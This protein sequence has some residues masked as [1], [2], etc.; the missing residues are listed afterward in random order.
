MKPCIKRLSLSGLR[1]EMTSRRLKESAPL[2]SALP[3]VF[4][5]K[6][7]FEERL[8]HRKRKFLEKAERKVI[9]RLAREQ[10]EFA[11]LN[12]VHFGNHNG[13]DSLGTGIYR[14]ND[15]ASLSKDRNQNA[16]GKSVETLNLTRFEKFTISNGHSPRFERSESKTLCSNGHGRLPGNFMTDIP[17]ENEQCLNGEQTG[18]SK[19]NSECKRTVLGPRLSL[20]TRIESKGLDWK[21]GAD[22]IRAK[23]A[24]VRRTEVTF[25]GKDGRSMSLTPVVRQFRNISLNDAFHSTSRTKSSGSQTC[26][27]K[28]VS[29]LPKAAQVQLKSSVYFLSEHKIKQQ[30]EMAKIRTKRALSARTLRH[31]SVT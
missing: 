5:R 7:I 8:L 10:E 13:S 28:T 30:A 15:D 22:R 6:N 19:K 17:N 29:D 18:F 20:P 16:S 9:D 21:S 23:S 27:I 26:F 31:N 2:R 3:D 4:L 14:D 12:C 24:P 11:I 1:A 25:S